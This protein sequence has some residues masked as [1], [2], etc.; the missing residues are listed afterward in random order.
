MLDGITGSASE[1]VGIRHEAQ[2]CSSVSA[3]LICMKRP[4]YTSS[5]AA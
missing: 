3:Q 2:H 5:G 4:L 1:N